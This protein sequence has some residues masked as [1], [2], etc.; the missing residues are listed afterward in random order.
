MP[1]LPPFYSL[2]HFFTSSLLLVC[3]KSDEIKENLHW[4]SRIY[5]TTSRSS[6]YE[7]LSTIRTLKLCSF[8]IFAFLYIIFTVEFS[9]KLRESLN[10]GKIW[11]N[12]TPHMV[13][14]RFSFSFTI[15][16]HVSNNANDDIRMNVVRE[17]STVKSEVKGGKYS[18]IPKKNRKRKK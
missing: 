5:K 10:K 9:W 8:Y 2:M 4:K 13:Y 1:I 11:K 14:F 15:I 6:S 7:P 17:L 12:F 3:L 18:K 16:S